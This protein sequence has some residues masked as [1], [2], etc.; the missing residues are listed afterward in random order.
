MVGLSVGV[1][2]RVSFDFE[3]AVRRN[4][5]PALVSDLILMLYSANLCAAI[6][7]Q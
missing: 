5:V 6:E 7:T 2:L 3:F 1:E 4:D